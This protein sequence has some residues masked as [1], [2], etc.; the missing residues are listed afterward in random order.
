MMSHYIR[1]YSCFSLSVYS[2]KVHGTPTCR[3]ANFFC[4][5]FH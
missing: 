5:M 1:W 2:I 4:A 3:D